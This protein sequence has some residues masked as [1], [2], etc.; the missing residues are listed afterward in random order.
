MGKAGGNEY[1]WAIIGWGGLFERRVSLKWQ[2]RFSLAYD[3]SQGVRAADLEPR[4]GISL[5]LF[6]CN[7]RESSWRPWAESVGEEGLQ[8]LSGTS[9]VS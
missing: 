1:N 5:Y 3:S 6:C 8:G 2:Q 4:V 7:P 9:S